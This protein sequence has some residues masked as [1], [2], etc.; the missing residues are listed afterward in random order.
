MINRCISLKTKPCPITTSNYST[1]AP[2]S[3]TAKRPLKR[4]RLTFSQCSNNGLFHF[5]YYKSGI[6]F[7]FFVLLLCSPSFPYNWRI[8]N[9]CGSI[10]S[11][12]SGNYQLISIQTILGQTVGQTVCNQLTYSTII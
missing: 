1:I 6:A 2:K 12:S 5:L 9:Q 10:V 7:D 11:M 3:C 4:H 8:A